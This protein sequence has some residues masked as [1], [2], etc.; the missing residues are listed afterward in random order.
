MSTDHLLLAGGGHAH[1]LVLRRWVMHPHLR[2]KGLITL[3]SRKSTTLY[4][5]MVPGLIAGHY[6][7][8]DLSIDLR[9][10]AEKAGVAFISAEIVGLD[11]KNNS[12]LLKDRPP[13]EFDQ[14]SLDV[15]AET[16][17][18]KGF[19]NSLEEDSIIA[20]KPLPEAL[21]WISNQDREDFL[22]NNDPLTVVGSGFSAVEVVL[23]LRTRWPLRKLYLQA[24][25]LKLNRVFRPLLFYSN[26]VLISPLK[27]IKGQT[28]LCTGSKAPCWIEKSNL[29]V[30]S[31][32]RVLTTQT[33]QVINHPNLFAVGDCGVINNHYRPASGVWAV[34]VA[35]PLAKNLERCSKNLKPVKWHPQKRALQLLGAGKTNSKDARAWAVW[36]DVVLGPNNW[37]W[38]LKQAIDKKFMEKFDLSEM[39]DSSNRTH[40]DMACRGCA[41]K[42]PAY[43]LREALRKSA[44]SDIAKYP[45][46][47]A[48]ISSL[49]GSESILQSVDG[50]PALI[51]DPWLNGRLTALHASSDIWAMGALVS[52][53]QVVI[54]LPNIS[55]EVQKELLAQS[56]SGINSALEE[57]GAKL[58]GGHTLEARSD[59]P[60]PSTL[61]IQIALSVNG[62]L[63][64]KLAPLTKAGL[65]L[66]D[67]ILISRSIGSG[68]LFAAA[69]LGKGLPRH[70]DDAL[71]EL[72][73]SQHNLLKRLIKFENQKNQGS[74]IHACTDITGFGLLGHLEEMLSASNSLRHQAGQPLVRIKLYADLIPSFNGV[75]SLFGAGYSSTLAPENR[76]AWNLLEKNGN[77]LAPIELSLGSGIRYG[78]KEYSAILD[79]IVDPQT[80]GPL[81]IACSSDVAGDLITSGPWKKIGDVEHLQG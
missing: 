23:A 14:L 7:I 74:A 63:S 12:V 61:G 39:D 5:G 45:E 58:L 15:G 8:D 59:S 41:A 20:I 35:K 9:G 17:C 68:V 16:K 19:N 76:K 75:L 26:I 34:R 33:L 31:S 70:L 25:L 27:S 57:Q 54:T 62:F 65:N 77:S 40:V 47:A 43:P 56:L 4:S 55:I 49:E 21:K 32:G 6:E 73:K 78:S 72:A 44:L 38:R 81:L 13:I 48:L 60:Y 30:D 64:G 37:L 18:S 11:T 50:F 52:S 29:P 46:D 51:S 3:I 10:L 80:C 2:P 67:Q 36:G 42:F 66:G 28:L 53:A 24:D 71:S 22:M 1:S 69:R 79:L